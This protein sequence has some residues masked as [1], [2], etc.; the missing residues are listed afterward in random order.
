MPPQQ[1][2]GPLDIFDGCFD[3]GFHYSAF[4]TAFFGGGASRNFSSQRI[5]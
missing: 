4:P 5:S 2:Q 3:F 1:T